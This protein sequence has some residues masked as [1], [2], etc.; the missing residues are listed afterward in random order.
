MTFDY[1]WRLRTKLPGRHG[2]PC[3]VFVRARMNS[4][5]V[6]F[7]DGLRVVTTRYA[8]RRAAPGGVPERGTWDTPPTAPAAN[9]TPGDQRD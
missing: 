2:Q 3:R 1:R 4:I 9:P 6:E 7:E 8:V 5:G